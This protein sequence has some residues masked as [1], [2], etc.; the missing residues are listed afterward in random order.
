MAE[1]FSRYQLASVR[2]GYGGCGEGLPGYGFS[3]YGEGLF[4]D[5]I[6]RL[7]VFD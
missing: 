4:E 3:K 1:R 7:K 6:L 5:L 2:Y